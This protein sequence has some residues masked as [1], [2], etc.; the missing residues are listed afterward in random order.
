[1]TPGLED[2]APEGASVM[3]MSRASLE[4]G[5]LHRKGRARSGHGPQAPPVRLGIQPP[6][7]QPQPRYLELS[8]FGN[9]RL[10]GVQV[11]RARAPDRRAE[12]RAHRGPIACSSPDVR[13]A[14]SA[15]QPGGTRAPGRAG[16]WERRPRGA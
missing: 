16:L 2:P 1:M 10:R 12:L 15:A 6:H 4:P 5:L 11:T 8:P 3:G 14:P 13:P 9:R 7:N